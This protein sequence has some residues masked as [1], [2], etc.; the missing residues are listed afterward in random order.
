MTKSSTKKTDEKTETVDVAELIE[1]ANELKIESSIVLSYIAKNDMEGLKKLIDK[2]RR[3]AAEQAEIDELIRNSKLD[4]KSL[5]LMGVALHGCTDKGFFYFDESD[6][7]WL[8][9]LLFQVFS[10]EFKEFLNSDKDLASTLTFVRYL[11]SKKTK[12]K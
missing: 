6:H 10:P 2:T 12:K 1:A 11:E 5:H 3:I 8:R 7:G 4:K 9:N